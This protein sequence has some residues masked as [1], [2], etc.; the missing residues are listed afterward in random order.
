[1][2]KPIVGGNPAKFNNIKVNK[3]AQK[4]SLV[5]KFLKSEICTNLYPVFNFKITTNNINK[6]VK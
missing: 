5:I 4:G 3:Q 6:L 1:M 2:K